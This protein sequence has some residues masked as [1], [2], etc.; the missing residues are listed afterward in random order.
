MTS[1]KAKGDAGEA[2]W[3]AHREKDGWICFP[4]SPSFE[5]ADLLSFDPFGG[6]EFA[7]VKAWNRPI[8]AQ[9]RQDVMERLLGIRSWF[10]ARVGVKRA[11]SVVLVH[12]VKG[13]DGEWRFAETWRFP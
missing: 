2:A 11:L 13:D 12:A 5:G 10:V 1:R 4:L 7:E 6:I 9:T 3:Q 8:N